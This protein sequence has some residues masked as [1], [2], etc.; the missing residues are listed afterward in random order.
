KKR[1]SAKVMLQSR[2]AKIA[3]NEDGTYK[4]SVR[5]NGKTEIHEF[6]HVVVALPNYWVSQ[7]E[8]EGREARMA[9]QK[10]QSRYD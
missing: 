2:V 6:D 3:R 8:F 1:I 4:L 5:R 7:I 10:H 9:I